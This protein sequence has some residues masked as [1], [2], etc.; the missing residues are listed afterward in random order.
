MWVIFTLLSIQSRIQIVCFGYHP[1][2]RL[3]S[4]QS[5]IQTQQIYFPPNYY[6]WLSAGALIFGHRWRFGESVRD[7]WDKN[8]CLRH[9][10]ELIAA[11]RTPVIAMSQQCH[12][13]VV[14]VWHRCHTLWSRG[15]TISAIIYQKSQY[16]KNH[17]TTFGEIKCIDIAFLKYSVVAEGLRICRS[18]HTYH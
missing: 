15:R 7:N 10:Y 17:W 2:C 18:Q 16:Q 5:D 13:R 3:P 8:Y 9:I 14:P 4:I 12:A 6:H 11:I 1:I